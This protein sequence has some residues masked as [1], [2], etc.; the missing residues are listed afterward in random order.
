[1]KRVSPEV[2]FTVFPYVERIFELIIHGRLATRE[3]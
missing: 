3:I 2:K 1:M